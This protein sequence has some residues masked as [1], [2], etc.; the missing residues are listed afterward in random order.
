MV[1]KN[2]LDVYRFDNWGTSTIPK[3]EV[4]FQ[5]DYFTSG[6]SFMTCCSCLNLWTKLSYIAIGIAHSAL[7]IDQLVTSRKFVR[8]LRAA[9]K[10]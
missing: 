7:L 10:M 1:Q 4:G 5:V 6:P 9:T 2:Y 3:F 8:T